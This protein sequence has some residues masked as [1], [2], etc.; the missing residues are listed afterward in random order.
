MLLIC[1]LLC[2]TSLCDRN[3]WWTLSGALSEYFCGG[4]PF[5]FVCL[6]G[7]VRTLEAVDRRLP[8]WPWGQISHELPHH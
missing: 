4:H 7:K 8:Y 1:N 6:P 3:A 5:H 2:M